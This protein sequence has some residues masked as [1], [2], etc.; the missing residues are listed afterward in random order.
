MLPSALQEFET[1]FRLKLW[2]CGNVGDDFVLNLVLVTSKKTQV[3]TKVKVR[4]PQTMRLGQISS[5][6]QSTLA[7]WN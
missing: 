2:V 7:V 5:S 3:T 1:V 6:T 4:E